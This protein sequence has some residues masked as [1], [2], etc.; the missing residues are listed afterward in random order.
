M[1]Y[2]YTDGSC[3]RNGKHNPDAGIGIFFGHN[4]VRNVSRKI[5]GKQTNNSAELSAV[6]AVH[7]IIQN[8]VHAGETFTIVTDSEY[9]IKCVTTYGERMSKNEWKKDIPN[10]ELVKVAYDMYKNHSSILFMHTI[11]HTK[12]KSIHAIGNAEADLLATLSTR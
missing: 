9:V 10:K 12:D 1:K 8:E 11:A 4:D 5:Y 2:I 3:K 7:D 6:I